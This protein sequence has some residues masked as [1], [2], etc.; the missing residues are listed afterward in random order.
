MTARRSTQN[1][2]IRLLL[3]SYGLE[4][5]L[6]V[7]DVE[8]EYVVGLLVDQGLIELEEYFNEDETDELGA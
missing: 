2:R 3:T 8:E 7:H 6:L 4:D 5:I 1:E